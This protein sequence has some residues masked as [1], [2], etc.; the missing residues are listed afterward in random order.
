MPS[1]PS[2]FAKR[3]FNPSEYLLK[4]CGIPYSQLFDYQGNCQSQAKKSRIERLSLSQVFQLREHDLNGD[5]I[6]IFDDVYTTGATLIRA[7]ECVIKKTNLSCRSLTLAR[8][9]LE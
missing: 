5:E 8:D 6:L 3:G 4:V 9:I 1:S 7:K 2:N